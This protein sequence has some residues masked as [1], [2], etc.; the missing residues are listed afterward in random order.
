MP[1]RCA[2]SLCLVTVLTLGFSTVGCRNILGYVATPFVYDEVPIAEE[3]VRRDLAYRA[4]EGFDAEKHRLDFFAPESSQSE[5][6]WPIVVFVHGGGWTSGDRA[7]R[8]GGADIYGNLGRY[9]AS[10]GIGA[11]VISYRLQFDVEW[12]D[13]VEDV[14]SAVA[15]VQDHA[16]NFGGDPDAV[17]LMGHSAGAQLASFV[18]FDREVARQHGAG[19]VCGVIPV[20]GAGYDLSDEVTYEQGAR[21]AYYERR[22]RIADEEWQRQASVL[23][24]IGSDAP[25]TLVLFAENDWDPLRHQAALLERALADAGAPVRLRQV[26]GRNHYTVLLALTD[27]AG[28]DVVEFVRNTACSRP[29]AG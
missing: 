20:S 3:R 14:A 2:R 5:G 12:T 7:Y 29:D 18:A 23:P 21:L 10:H 9:L 4:G 13:Q 1:I 27:D 16:G 8:V 17:F 22:F 6:G 26:D 24:R 15:W 19:P 28:P 11:A 25:P